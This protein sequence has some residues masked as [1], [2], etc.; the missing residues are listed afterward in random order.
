MTWALQLR[1]Y[2]PTIP[3]EIWYE[4]SL[5]DEI[6]ECAKSLNIKTVKKEKLENDFKFPSGLHNKA[7]HN[8]FF[9]LYNICNESEP[10][11]FID[12]DAFVLSPLTPLLEASKDKPFIAI[13]HE[14]IEGHTAHLPYDFIN[15]GVL[16]VS[17]PSFL[18]FDEKLGILKKDKGFAYPGTEQSLMNSYMVENKYDPTH[19]SIGPGWN[20]CAGFTRFN[21]DGTAYSEGLS[22]E[23][24]IYINHYW[25]TY[26][27]WNVNCPLYNKNK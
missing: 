5:S 15:T 2:E 1:K 25:Y 14:K 3:V 11:I 8:I 27:P 13:N 6:S 4:S 20:H 17:D 19:P 18:D 26:K 12:A 10:F 9:K 21:E 24:P 7:Q 23:Y 16:I 22:E